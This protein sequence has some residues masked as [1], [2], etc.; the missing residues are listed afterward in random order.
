MRTLLITG[1]TGFIGTNFIHHAL[2]ARP[3]WHIVNLDALTYA[4]NL[5]N[6]RDLPRSQAERH[7]FI[8]GDIRD[9]SLLHRLFSKDTFDGVIHFAA[10]SHVDRSIV[11]PEAFLETNILGTFRLLEASLKHWECRGRPEGFRFVHI[12]TDEVY[13][14]LGAEGYFTEKTPY[15]PSNPYSASKAAS[16]HFV[17]AYFLTYGLPT[18][19][20]NCS[21]NFGPY[22]FPE[23]LIP[24]VISNI[25]EEKPLPVYGDGKNI[26]DW[27]YV[28][29]HYEALIKAFEE[30]KPGETYVIGGRAERQNI[31]IVE[32]LC[33][34]LD[35]R[36]GRCSR[37]SSRQLIRFIT[38][39]PGHDRRYAIDA[40]KIQ[41]EL[42]WSPQ[43]HFEEALEATVNWYLNN[44][45]WV[46]SVRS[47]EYQRWIEMNYVH[48]ELRAPTGQSGKDA[49]GV[50][51]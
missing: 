48:R 5:G 47:A 32:L 45:D 23:K 22:Q 50:K 2:T 31:E 19:V 33:D 51:P 14:S 7:S 27:L 36:L 18:I 30:G 20:T 9:T 39:R 44:M 13:G 16:D 1:G 42:G 17:K 24:L 12:S 8:Y 15:D 29:D 28:I 43:H 35:A 4:G 49:W 6:F 46:Q 37:Q 10:E 41:L 26:R 3:N 11:G 25:L 38:D 40:S 34:L 21:N